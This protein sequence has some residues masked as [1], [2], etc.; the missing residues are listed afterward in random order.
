MKSMFTFSLSKC[1][2]ITLLLFGCH[3]FSA[4]DV[5]NGD[6]NQDFDPA[7]KFPTHHDDDHNT[8]RQDEVYAIVEVVKGV[9]L[10]NCKVISQDMGLKRTAFTVQLGDEELVFRFLA[11]GDQQKIRLM[12]GE[13]DIGTIARDSFDRSCQEDQ[14][15][16]DIKV[17]QTSGRV[18]DVS[19][20][21]VKNGQRGY[22]RA[23]EDLMKVTIESS[24]G[25]KPVILRSCVPCLDGF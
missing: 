4:T 2:L 1:L 8:V 6:G 3:E 7:S 13:G 19:I 5:D 14:E 10:K 18:L 15:T 12:L 24:T 9:F 22:G 25:E 20:V 16:G 11:S 17:I 21:D 23:R